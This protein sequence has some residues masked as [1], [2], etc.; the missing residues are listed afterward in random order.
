MR[1]RANFGTSKS[2]STCAN[3]S[4]AMAGFWKSCRWT[5]KFRLSGSGFRGNRKKQSTKFAQRME[6]SF[7]TR[8]ETEGLLIFGE[9]G[10]DALAYFGI[11]WGGVFDS[12]QAHSRKARLDAAV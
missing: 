3:R 2:N 4:R 7:A 8:R 10:L 9:P 6:L 12:I 11:R 5:R 1:W